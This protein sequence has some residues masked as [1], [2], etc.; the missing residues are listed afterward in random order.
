VSGVA[1]LAAALVFAA[2]SAQ[3]ALI[4]L[5]TL[6]A[7]GTSNGAIFQQGSRGG[8]AVRFHLQDRARG[9]TGVTHVAFFNVDRRPLDESLFL[10][11]PVKITAAVNGSD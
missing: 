1:L 6:G 7:Q 3:A 2:S 10:P 11:A 5:T 9:E 8:R 4:D